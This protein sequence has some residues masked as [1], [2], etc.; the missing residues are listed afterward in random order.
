ME[1]NHLVVNETR[2]MVHLGSVSRTY[3]LS[4]RAAPP[5]GCQPLREHSRKSCHYRLHL[6]TCA[7]LKGFS[8]DT[9]RTY[10]QA[11]L[12]ELKKKE[13]QRKKHKLFFQNFLM[14][15]SSFLFLPIY[16][17]CTVLF[18]FLLVY[19]SAFLFLPFS[20]A[21]FT[22]S[23]LSTLWGFR[24]E[25]ILSDIEVLHHKLISIECGKETVQLRKKKWFVC[26]GHVS[27][28]LLSKNSYSPKYDF[29]RFI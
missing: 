12:N 6:P 16:T 5:P 22:I 27:M 10:F 28:M 25:V 4:A 19:L 9:T 18:C 29:P 17:G 23:M 11:G 1:L 24:V 8:C 20:L 26:F 2:G 3:Q 7:H 15:L 13:P 14:Q 21:L